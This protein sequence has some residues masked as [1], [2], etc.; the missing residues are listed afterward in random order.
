VWHFSGGDT[1]QLELAAGNVGDI[2]VV[3]GRAEIFVLL[4][5]E[6]VEGDQMDLGVAVLAS[7][8]G[9]HINNLAGAVLDDDEA[10]LAESRALHGVGQRGAGVGGLEGDIMLAKKTRL[11]TDLAN[12]KIF[13]LVFDVGTSER[14]SALPTKTISFYK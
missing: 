13:P 8:G 9:R 10:V 1:Y 12:I 7:L 11:A 14:I 4:A 6:D 3:G 5:G 2:H